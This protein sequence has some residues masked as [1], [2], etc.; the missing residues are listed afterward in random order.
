M[1][2]VGE[3]YQALREHDQERRQERLDRNTEVYDQANWEIH[4][5]YHWGRWVRS[6]KLDFWPSK[7]KWMYEGRVRVGGLDSWLKSRGEDP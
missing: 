6:K 4:T 3:M 5:P 2:E 7:D 1:S